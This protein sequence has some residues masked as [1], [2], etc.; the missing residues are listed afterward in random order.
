MR[1]VTAW[2]GHRRCPVPAR[3]SRRCCDR[4]HCSSPAPLRRR[5]CP[6]PAPLRRR[7]CPPPA[8]LRRRHCSGP[9]AVCGAGVAAP[10]G[11][12][13]RR[14]AP[15]EHAAGHG[16]HLCHVCIRRLDEPAITRPSA[17]A[18]G[19]DA[20]RS[21]VGRSDA[22]GSEAGRSDEAGHRGRREDPP[23]SAANAAATNPIRRSRGGWRA[24]KYGSQRGH[25]GRR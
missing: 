8:P 5:Y 22:A 23:G 24:V 12:E 3:V 9:A 18:A 16:V 14:R 25:R 19:S 2:Q 4:R 7:Y 21:E 15:R 17:G 13:P 1:G 10:S 20:A 6:S 11:A